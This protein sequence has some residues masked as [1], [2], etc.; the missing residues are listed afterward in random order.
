MPPTGALFVLFAVSFFLLRLVFAE[1]AFLDSQIGESYGDYLRATPRLFPRFHASL[2]PSG[3]KPQWLRGV[4]SE[5]APLGIFLALAF[6][7]WSFDLARMTRTIVV[8]YGIG[9]V[10]RAAVMGER[11]Q[12]GLP[13]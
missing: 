10:A 11:R 6:E 13:E 12:P 4:L 2:L 1:E 9:L 8:F 7:S 5:I 3:R